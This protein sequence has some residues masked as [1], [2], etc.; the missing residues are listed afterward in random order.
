[1]LRPE[2]LLA[3]FQRYQPSHTAVVPSLLTAFEKAAQ[4]KLDAAPP[5]QAFL[6]EAATRLPVRAKHPLATAFGGRLEAMF[7]GGAFTDRRRADWFAERGLPVVIGYGLTECCAV[8]ALN[9]L[10]PLRADS[11][12][13]A[14]E[15]VEIAI[16]TPDPAGVGEVWI[17]G[18]TLMLG[19]LDDPALT[20]ETLTADG[21]LRTG[22]LGWLDGSFHLH[23]VGRNKDVIVTEGG[24]NVYPED[25]EL[26]FGAL[27]CEEIAVFAENYVW[28]QRRLTG[29]RLVAVV[30]PRGDLP[31]ESLR[32][33]NLGLADF[34]RLS[35]VVPWSEGFPRTATLK[36]KRA[37]LA[38]RVGAAVPRE[39]VV[40]L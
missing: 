22:D 4:E 40:P 32:R 19:Y 1:V 27:D 34:K 35:G 18:P 26:A 37:E 14:V 25:V 16:H 12:G 6:A 8:A 38:A 21:W 2:H 30:R 3:T 31:V 13:C 15:G 11:V 36:L 28:P 33:V 17:R 9:R 5:W 23:L 10:R 7:C 39:Q 29:E 20:A 24:K